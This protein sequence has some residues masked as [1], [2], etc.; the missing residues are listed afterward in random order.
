MGEMRY[1]L[2]CILILAVLIGIAFLRSLKPYD[3]V[4]FTD[5]IPFRKE[6]L[7]K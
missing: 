1:R 3:C 7:R 5:L 2:G 4:V 6:T